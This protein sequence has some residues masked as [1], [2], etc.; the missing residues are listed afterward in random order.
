MRYSICTG[1]VLALLLS[2]F[3]LVACSEQQGSQPQLSVGAEKGQP[4]PDFTLKDMQG[5]NVSLVDLKGKVV[6]LGQL[7][8]EGGVVDGKE[9]PQLVVQMTEHQLVR[10]GLEQ[11]VEQSHRVP[12]S[13]P[14]SGKCQPR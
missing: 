4:A 6:F 1:F 13:E 2:S 14:T 5:Q 12:I 8:H 9:S 11:G 7:P 3:F 10:S